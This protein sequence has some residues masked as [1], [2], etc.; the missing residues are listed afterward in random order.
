MSDSFGHGTDAPRM[1]FE[2]TIFRFNGA[3]APASHSGVD[4]VRCGC[5]PTDI[6]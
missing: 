6:A 4:A 1:H 3:S 5:Y 2:E